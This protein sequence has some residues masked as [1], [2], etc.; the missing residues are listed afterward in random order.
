[1]SPPS[2]TSVS[3]GVAAG[4]LGADPGQLGLDR[5]WAGYLD[6]RAPAGQVPG[7]VQR[8]GCAE[9]NPGPPV[10]KLAVGVAVP[11]E[12]GS[13]DRHAPPT[14]DQPPPRPGCG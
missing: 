3:A 12:L 7:D 6:H 13:Q 10:V 8:G 9:V 11:P 14:S 2:S 1:M 5:W 4:E